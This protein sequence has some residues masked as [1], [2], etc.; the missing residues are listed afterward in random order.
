[1]ERV[2][3]A[4]DLDARAARST[5]GSFLILAADL[6]FLGGGEAGVFFLVPGSSL[7]GVD[8]CLRAAFGF[9]RTTGGAVME[10]G[11]KG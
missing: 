1:M 3:G 7:M 8:F 9:L 4:W 10:G 6:V 2:S 5:I 11:S